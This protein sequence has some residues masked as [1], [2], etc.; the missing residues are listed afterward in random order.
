[1]I[2]TTEKKI[3]AIG[4]IHG[5]YR[6]LVDLMNRL[7]YDPERD[8][9]IFLGDYI[10]RGPDSAKVIDYLLELQ[11][12]CRDVIFLKGNHEQALVQY[13]DTGDTEALRY[14]RQMGLEKMLDDYG[15][16][17][18]RLRGLACL[19]VEHQ[20]FLRTLK[21]G[22]VFGRAIFIHADFDEAM[23]EAV[24]GVELVCADNPATEAALL[25]SR[26]L[27]QEEFSLPD[28]LI[29]FGHVPFSAPLSGRTGS[30][31]TPVPSTVMF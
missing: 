15:A 10:N 12:S 2:G 11:E 22:V 19:P 29:V 17:I 27:V 24:S 13:A 6:K 9:L 28:H 21:F 20:A 26:R 31:S 8:R 18:G 5:C 25:S 1:M 16:S 7:P 30:G 23:L 14:L 3:F 4:D